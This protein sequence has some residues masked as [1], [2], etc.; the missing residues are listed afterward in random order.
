MDKVE[1]KA[2]AQKR[3][4]EVAVIGG[5]CAG[6]TAAFELTRP[7]HQGKYHVTIYQLGWRLGGKGAS[8]RGPAD[9]IEEH[10]LHIWQGYYDNAF[11]LLRECYAELNRDREKCRLADWQDAFSPETV[12]GVKDRSS[13]GTWLDWIAVFPPAPGLPG[14]P[15][16]E[17]DRFSVSSYLVRS[18]ALLQSVLVAAQTRQNPSRVQPRTDNLNRGESQSQAK[19]KPTGDPPGDE[20]VDSITRLMKYGALATM[21]GL[22]E[23]TKI[24][25]PIFTSSSAYPDNMVL[26]LL[27]AITLNTRQQLESLIANDD[28]MRRLWEIAD[29]TLAF[30]RGATRFRLASDP[31]GFDAINDY[32]TR[33]WLRLNGASE[34]ALN[35]SFLR[36]LYDL[37]F[38]YEDGDF[39]RP[40]VAAGQGMRGTMRMLLTYRGAIFWKMRAGMG[41]VVFAPFYEVLK[42]RGAS[43]KFFHRLENVKLV[44]P[45]KLAPGEHPYV[46]ALEFDVQAEIKDDNE[47]Q[48]LVDIRGLPCWPSRP[49]YGQLVDGE[50]FEREEWDFESFWDQRK[51]STK[52]LRVVDDFD[53][54]VLGIGI[55][56]VPFVCQE[57]ID[58]DVRWQQ[59]V[60]HVKTT[61]TQAFQ[62][63]LREDLP[64]LGWSRPPMCVAGFVHPFDTW[65]DM[66]HLATEERWPSKPQ[67]VAYF[68]SVL[69]DPPT[70]PDRSETDY[71]VRRREEVRRDAIS[72]LN[73][74][75]KHLWPQAVRESGEFR[76]ELVL[77]PTE[78]ESSDATGNQNE[79][80]FTSQ[81]W[82]ANVNPS[83]R[84]VLFL[85]GSLKYRISPL[86]NTYDNLTIAGDWTDCGFNAGCVEAAV[87]SGR[88]AAHA[89]SHFPPLE[90]IVGY[91]HP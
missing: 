62:L 9:R 42:K 77:N 75:A 65:A 17:Q 91:D 72:L 76:W 5:G 83:D 3:P 13:N 61:A 71:P 78:Q 1:A 85:P 35:S 12:V 28:E 15:V 40:R 32:E 67:T 47:Y 55:G 70:P 34:R 36:G 79:A 10:G 74:N 68:C 82:T 84:Y 81:F 18:A 54:V 66:S 7:E 8:G 37:V 49:D 48:P 29:L 60:K 2:V 87:M 46:E 44:D 57:L 38:G 6:I 16:T 50:R 25:E 86:D 39:A 59:M 4:I 51:V 19:A 80:R 69:P 31:R 23:A 90:D 64:T 88:L 11:R 52:T 41:D 26:R 30:L 21:T 73:H 24:L 20:V 58:R 22:I 89:L 27:E 33:E 63:W 53:C 43:F 14:D 45:A 56:A